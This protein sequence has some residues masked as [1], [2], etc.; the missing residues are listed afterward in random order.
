MVLIYKGNGEFRGIRLV[1]ALWKALLGGISWHI[2][3]AVNFHNVLHVFQAGLV[4]G[5]NSPKS[6]LHQQMRAIRSEV[7]NKVFL[8][9][10]K[11]CD[12]LEGEQCM[13]IL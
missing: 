8:D 10:Q 2:R 11:A 13:E 4:M 9:L 3:A 7:L 12:S 5:T 6:K 1:E